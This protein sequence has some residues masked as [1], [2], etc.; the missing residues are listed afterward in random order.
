MGELIDLKLL[1]RAYRILDNFV[2][3]RLELP[4]NEQGETCVDLIDQTVAW[5]CDWLRRRGG[6]SPSPAER[7]AM[8]RHLSRLLENQALEHSN[9]SF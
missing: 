1:R 2:G 5:C 9:L 8:R 4:S 6:R 7:R 3:E